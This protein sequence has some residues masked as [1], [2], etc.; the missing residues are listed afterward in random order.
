M[1]I[2]FDIPKLKQI[3]TDFYKLT[4]IVVSF[5]DTAFTNITSSDQLSDFCSYVYNDYVKS[6]KECDLYHLCQT[7]Q[8]KKPLT[9]TC[10]MGI[11][12]SIIP[13]YYDNNIIAYVIMGQ[14]RDI[15]GHY[16]SEE[17]ML[18]L[19]K[20]KSLDSQKLSKFYNELP[21]FS[22]EE[23]DAA[24]NILDNL[25]TLMWK[26]EIFK[27]DNDSIYSKIDNFIDNHIDEKLLIADLCRNFFISKNTL[28]K[29]FK[30]NYNL[31]VN[32]YITY[33]H[34]NYS[35]NLLKNGHLSITAIAS[36]SGF[37]DANYYN[38]IFKK[39]FHVSPSTFRKNLTPHIFINNK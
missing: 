26:N 18:D 3:C 39:H 24:F 28:Y 27:P 37:S 12:E 1:K 16:S 25:I 20:N 34:L 32:E 15:E 17:K 14:Y 31:S 11:T 33:R 8:N 38:R 10:H 35:L 4:H 29:M 7:K 23:I 6:C 30:Q 13:V 9:Y 5:C 2:L 19:T 36:M 21:L 22:K